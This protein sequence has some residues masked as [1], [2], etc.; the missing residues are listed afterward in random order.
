[1]SEV[2]I[3]LGA[4]ATIKYTID[5]AAIAGI[6][7]AVGTGVDS[8]IMIIDEIL[9]RDTEQTRTLKQ[10]IKR[11]FFII[12]GSATTTI[13]AMVPLMVIGIGVMRGFA[14]VAT[15]GVL[16]GIFITRPAFGRIAE[17]LIGNEPIISAE[18]SK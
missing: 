12:M 9:M 5:L 17:M 3:I 4:A 16:I 14:I 2:L 7:A 13:A 11:A 6:I 15:I 10:K 18:K 8:Q 1:M